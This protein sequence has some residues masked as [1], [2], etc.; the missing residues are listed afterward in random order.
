[1][2]ICGTNQFRLLR[3]PVYNICATYVKSTILI[4]NPSKNPMIHYGYF[5]TGSGLELVLKRRSNVKYVIQANKGVGFKT[6]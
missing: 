3:Q 5:M 6:A 1:M 4:W 2:V